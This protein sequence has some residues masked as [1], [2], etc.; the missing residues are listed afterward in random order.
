M[1]KTSRSAG[2]VPKVSGVSKPQPAEKAKPEGGVSTSVGAKPVKPAAAL[3]KVLGA[4]WLLGE[5][6]SGRPLTAGYAGLGLRQLGQR[7][8]AVP[9][10]GL[11]GFLCCSSE[12]SRWWAP[13]RGTVS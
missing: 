11:T 4:R 13:S 9:S 10:G 6:V 1:K 3:T 5:G 2:S 12:C 7:P 8:K